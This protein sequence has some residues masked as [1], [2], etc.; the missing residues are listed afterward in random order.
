MA[1]VPPLVN[2]SEY[3]IPS[4]MISFGA[5]TVLSTII[6]G[7]YMKETKGKTPEEKKEMFA[8]GNAGFSKEPLTGRNSEY[9]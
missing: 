7:V 4:L 5:L 6:Q 1:I 9:V 2:G 3:G 8:L